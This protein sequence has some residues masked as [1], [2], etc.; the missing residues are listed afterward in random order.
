MFAQE[1]FGK[2]A[3]WYL[4][5]DGLQHGEGQGYAHIYYDKDSIINGIEYQEMIFFLKIIIR[6]GPNPEDLAFLSNGVVRKFFY[7]TE[8][9]KVY[10]HNFDLTDEIL[11]FDFNA[12]VGDTVYFRD[13]LLNS[14]VECTQRPGYVVTGVGTEMIDGTPMPYWDIDS[15]FWGGEFLDGNRIY[16][17]MGVLHTLGTTRVHNCNPIYSHLNFFS[18]RCFTNDSIHFQTSWWNRDCDYFPFT[19]SVESHEHE[20]S[21]VIYP[22]PAEDIL[23]L[24]M[25]DQIEPT[26]LEITDLQGRQVCHQT[27]EVSRDTHISV[28]HLRSGMYVLRVADAEGKLLYSA[29]WVKK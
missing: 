12:Q 6:T 24:K 1:P 14:A 11:M 25:S 29:K 8:N 10:Y 13:T 5:F 16:K 27:M 21:F 28:G 3:E 19:I 7:R 4:S 15:I 23:R 20:D 2:N 22:N 18:T 9:N 26:F 17:D